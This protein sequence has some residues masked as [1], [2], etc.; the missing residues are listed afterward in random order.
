VIGNWTNNG[1]TINP[2][3][4]TVMFDFSTAASLSVAVTGSSTFYNLSVGAAASLGSGDSVVF[5]VATGTTLTVQGDF[6]MNS[7]FSTTALLGGG[8]INIWGNIDGGNNLHASASTVGIALTG[9]STQIVDNFTSNGTALTLPNLTV[10]KLSGVAYVANSSTVSG[11]VFVTQGELQVA[12]GTNPLTFTINGSV[13]VSSGGTLS[14]YAQQ[15]L[16]TLALGSTV[17]NNGLVFFDGGTLQCGSSIIDNVW[18]KS[19]GAS[20]TWSGPGNYIIRYTTVQSQKGP[21]TAL[22]ST[23]YLNSSNWTFTTGPYEELVQM[24]SSSA[25]AN[26]FAIPFGFSPRAGD[27][28][29]VAVSAKNQTIFTPTDTASNTYYLVASSTL[30][31]SPSYG[32]SLYYAKNI[33]SSSTFNVSVSGSGGAGNLLSAEAFEYTGMTPTSTFDTYS[34]NQDTTGNAILLTSNSATATSTNDL[35]FGIATFVA[36]TT[37]LPGSGWS[38]AGNITAGQPLYAENILSSVSQNTAATWT[39]NASTSYAAIIGDFEIPLATAYAASGTLDSQTF[40]TGVTAGVQLNSIV[41]QGS[42]PVNTTVQFQI[43]PS[44]SSAGPWN[45]VGPDGLSDTYFSPARGTP[46]SLVTNSGYTL[47]SGYRYF[48]YRV[49]LGTANPNVTPTVT[50]VAVN[51]SP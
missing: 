19:V 2:G 15:G 37:L 20:T 43:A 26:S 38:T 28:I 8:Q 9:T 12:T 14:D 10:S 35:F 42:E 31:G 22:N 33:I 41:W 3:T 13:T 39:A 46:M 21:V 7:H 16:S 47:F 44:N 11:N 5:T 34:V 27:L 40:D 36:P 1:T 6:A 24:A 32:L 17:T 25:A 50:G 29:L 30:S 49:A 4:S 45:F 23:N 51:W 18:I 48:R